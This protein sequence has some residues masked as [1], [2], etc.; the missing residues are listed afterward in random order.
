VTRRE[1]IAIIASAIAWPLTVHAQQARAPMLIGWLG[2]STKDAARAHFSAFLEGLRD[3]G[4]KDGD[5]IH[6]EYRFAD[7][8]YTRVPALAKEVV[9]LNPHVIL[10]ATISTTLALA[11]IT[12][13][14]PIVTPL[15]IDPVGYGLADSYNHPGHNV[16][17]VLMTLDSLPAKQAELL[18]RAIPRAAAIGVLV[19]PR[20]GAGAKT[21]HNLQAALGQTHIKIVPVEA[22]SAADIKTAFERLKREQVDGMVTLQDI[23]FFSHTRLITALAQAA[24]LPAI[25]GFRQDVEQGGL[26]S[27]GV[28]ISQN[29]RR[30]AY[31]VDR[32][33]KGDRA[34]DLP[35]ELP[36]KLELVINLKAAEALGIQIPPTV[37]AVADEIIE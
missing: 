25:Y 12:S 36:T 23:L 8:D 31:F 26:M 7:G 32:I 16:T 18:L 27:Y 21:V 22:G 6:I 37:L 1:F 30:A 11:K 5:D 4:H 33:L 19:N 24:R 15:A 20:S 9:A 3:L 29:F 13:S 17:G 2:G 14:V 35:I 34:G 28:N 10:S